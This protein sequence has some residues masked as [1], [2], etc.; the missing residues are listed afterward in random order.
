MKKKVAII[1]G[2][3]LNQMEGVT[4]IAN[5]RVETDFGLPSSEIVELKIN[6]SGQ[7]CEFFFLPRH[8]SPHSIAPHRI[9]YRANIAALN[10][11]GVSKILAV[12]A[13]GSI[14]PQLHPKSIVMPEQA[15]DYSHGRESSFFDGTVKPL[16]HFDF[17]NPFNS[18]LMA[19][20]EAA[21]HESSTPIVR[22]GVYGVTQGPRLETAAE[23]RRMAQDGCTLVGMTLMP[24]AVLAREL[25]MAYAA[26][27]LVVNPAAGVS[28]DVITMDE[29]HQA[30][31]DGMGQMHILLKKALMLLNGQALN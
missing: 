25:G 28:N 26:L 14:D 9:N 27:C 7:D 2:T 21:A 24:E 12:N 1:G 6:A 11:L 5:H 29:I 30:V 10:I 23:I 3:G 15:I 19:V 20:C 22:G 17:S 18:E 8:G 4:H 16:Q 31:A 13:V